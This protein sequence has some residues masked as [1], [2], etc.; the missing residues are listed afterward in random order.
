[1]NTKYI[2]LINQTF[3]FPQSEFAL[4]NNKLFFHDI[5]LNKLVEVYGAPLKFTYLP[6]ISNNINRAKKWFEKAFLKHN[7]KGYY[8]YCYCTKSSHFKHILDEALKNDI[9][10]ETSSTFDIDIVENLKKTGKINNETYIICNGFKREQYITNIARLI[11]NGHQNCIPVIDNYEE[12]NLLSNEINGNFDIG[13]RIA[14]EEEPKFEFYTSRLGIGYKNIVPFYNRQIK[15]NPQVKLKMLHFFINTGIRD[16]AYYWNELL[17]CLKVYTSLKKVCP[18]LDSLNIGGGFPIKSSLAFDFDY[19]YMVD[20]IVNQIKQACEEE[21]VDVPNIFTEFGSFTV[22]ESGGAIYE[23]LYQKQQND[24]EKWNM[25]N[26]SFITT[27][28]DTWAINKRFVMLPINRWNSSYER[29]LLGG[30]TCDSDDYYNSEQHINAIYLPKYD[31]DKPLYVGFFNTG[32]YQ[33]TI[34]GFGGLQHCLIPN[35]KHILIDKDEQ[36]N[37]ITT[38]FKEQQKSEDL[39][40]ILGYKKEP[41]VE[42]NIEILETE[43]NLQLADK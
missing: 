28:P 4:E 10:I 1:M 14:S 40:E 43:N 8:N 37:I 31:K 6:Q 22:G 32:A 39:L 21:G 24:R 7:Y 42:E 3:D 27:L 33:E 30:L 35:P 38:L 41:L 17:K 29:V 19:E 9:H 2:D 12:I 25:I 16:N 5:D 34:G 23:V 15:D 36:G 13:I 18:S 20:E 26:S 11:N